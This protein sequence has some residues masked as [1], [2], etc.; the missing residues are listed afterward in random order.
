M[1]IVRANL[2]RKYGLGLGCSLFSLFKFERLCLIKSKKVTCMGEESTGYE[3][4]EEAPLPQQS[5]VGWG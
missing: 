4:N 1:H 3:I 5:S 2:N